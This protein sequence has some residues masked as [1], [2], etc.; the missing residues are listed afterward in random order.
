[1]PQGFT[2]LHVASTH[3]SEQCVAFLLETYPDLKYHDDAIL[4]ENPAHQAAKH[5]HSSVY[6]QLV[7]HGTRDDLE[8]LQVRLWGF[9]LGAKSSRCASV[10]A[11]R[12]VIL[13][14]CCVGRHSKRFRDVQLAVLLLNLP[15]KRA[16]LPRC[17][18][19]TS[20]IL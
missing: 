2:A 13:L 9:W 11:N 18:K 5:L 12:V 17:C 8:N 16:Q 3:G 20:L 4:K 19:F 6:K 1:M 15:K 10:L 14:F 7:A